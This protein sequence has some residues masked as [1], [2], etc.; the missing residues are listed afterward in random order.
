[1]LKIIDISEIPRKFKSLI[2]AT[3]RGESFVVL[4]NDEPV[5]NIVPFK[6]APPSNLADFKALQFNGGGDLSQNVDSIVYGV[7]R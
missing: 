3:E 4:K 7:S 5:F 6:K 1:M 2:K